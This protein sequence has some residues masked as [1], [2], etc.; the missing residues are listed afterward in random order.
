MPKNMNNSKKLQGSAV[1]ASS[2]G[3]FVSFIIANIQSCINTSYVYCSQ[4]T[5]PRTSYS[6]YGTT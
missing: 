6:L 3:G 1:Q 5:I 2:Q 4:V